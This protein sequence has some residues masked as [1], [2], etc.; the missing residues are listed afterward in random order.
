MLAISPMPLAFVSLA[1]PLMLAGGLLASLPIAAHL[2][3]RRPSLRAYFPS[4]ELLAACRAGQSALHRLRRW[5]LL[6]LRLLAVAALVLAFT[7]PLWFGGQKAQADDPLHGVAVVL[8]LDASLSTTQPLSSGSAFSNLQS[9]AHR[10]LDAM[11]PGR[12]VVGLVV[13]D[14]APRT[15]L[16]GMSANPGA[17]AREVDRAHA[18]FAC[19]DLPAAI[20]RAGTLLTGGKG[21][22]PGRIV[23][24]TDLQAT[25]LD[26]AALR[27]AAQALPPGTVV[28]VEFPEFP[29]DPGIF[30]ANNTLESLRVEP[31]TPAAGE[32]ARVVVRA[33]RH[34]GGPR[35]AA[36]FLEVEGM[37]APMQ[38]TLALPAHG[39]AEASFNVPFPRAGWRRLKARLADDDARADALSADDAAYA[40]VRVADRR[41][42]VLVAADGP[43]TPG[44]DCWFLARALAPSAGAGDPFSVRHLTPA[45]VTPAGLERADCVCV[46]AGGPWPA[47][48]MAG[49]ARFLKKGGHAVFFGGPGALPDNLAALAKAVGE[50]VAPCP[51]RA[52]TR[53]DAD[54][55]W[56]RLGAVGNAQ[57]AG[58]PL[59]AFDPQSREAL[60]KI[61]FRRAWTLGDPL[62]GAQVFL[63]WE[64][65]APAA[66]TL[67]LACGGRITL[68]AF[69]TGLADGDLPKHGA[70]VALAQELAG[71]RA[72]GQATIGPARCG[73]PAVFPSLMP[74][75]A[76]GGAPQVV[77]PDGKEVAQASF[78]LLG[79]L[80]VATAAAPEI[81]G[82]YTA[83][84]ETD[85]KSVTLGL[86][87]VN[88]DAREGDL[89]RAGISDLRAALGAQ[90]VDAKNP[91][92]A[93]AAQA[94]RDAGG[95]PMWGWLAALALLFLGLE[96]LVAGGIRR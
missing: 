27:A 31:A 96:M 86:L 57:S 52:F 36:V 90:A 16:A 56:R 3:S 39:F 92:R 67:P 71:L 14:A 45:E 47:T 51:V 25:Q 26:R 72:G 44:S 58:G 85:G 70:V 4:L 79:D 68:C 65:G 21:G 69:G 61:A 94:V 7:Q 17:V 38:A 35:E 19:A 88:V 89:R 37:A 95:I 84:Q 93:D 75:A 91:A 29:A 40:A 33:A 81:P 80:P 20:A 9:R 11:T 48:A 54:G 46:L 13:A 6:V 41:E 53:W 12:D 30:P 74:L 82:I 23:L 76:D 66:A 1:A 24:L 5:I 50:P 78:D 32:T 49:L 43:G 18:G 55:S 10:V 2:M 28:D 62:P 22:R 42:V 63:R 87:A 77:G 15:P 73:T 64:T 34:G 8:V 60:R 83:R 59:A